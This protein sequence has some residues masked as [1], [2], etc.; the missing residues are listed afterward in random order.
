LAE[1]SD[2]KTYKLQKT[3]DISAGGGRRGCKELRTVINNALAAIMMS[4]LV[5]STSQRR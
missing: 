2:D 4:S 1:E 5:A 3:T